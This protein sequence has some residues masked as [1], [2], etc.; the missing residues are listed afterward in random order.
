MN[1]PENTELHRGHYFID[2][3]G[4]AILF[5]AKGHNIIGTAGCSRFSML[6]LLDVKDPEALT[7]G[8]DDLRTEFASDPYFK[9][10]PSMQLRQQKTAKFFH[11]K[12]DIPE[13][14]YKVFSLL[15]RQDIRF[16]AVVQDKQEVLK[17]VK[18]RND[19]DASFKYHPNQS[20]DYQVRCLLNGPLA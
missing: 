2:E 8:L 17:Y 9:D 19:E 6:G 16:Y 11:A 1:L 18:G 7:K 4:D 13:V 10:V 5:N 14:R 15:M 3:A 20:Y 12:D